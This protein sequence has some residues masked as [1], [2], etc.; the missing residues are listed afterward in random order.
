MNKQVVNGQSES[1][2]DAMNLIDT[3]NKKLKHIFD[4][5]SEQAA[6]TV[7]NLRDRTVRISK[8]AAKKID[9]SAHERVWTFVGAAA[10]FSALSGVLFGRWMATRRVK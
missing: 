6:E 8:N 4:E 7:S 9:D 10:A 5:T 3:A 2:S 1:L